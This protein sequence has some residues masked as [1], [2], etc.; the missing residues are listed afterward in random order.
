MINLLDYLFY[1]EKLKICMTIFK[2]YFSYVRMYN[3]WICF[4]LKL[5]IRGDWTKRSFDVVKSVFEW[6][7]TWKASTSTSKSANEWQSSLRYNE[8][9]L[10]IVRVGFYIVWTVKN[11]HVWSSVLGRGQLIVSNGGRLLRVR[12][13]CRFHG[14]EY[15]EPSTSYHD[16]LSLVSWLTLNKC[17]KIYH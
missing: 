12:I 17:P 11:A 5:K 15:L 4:E 13:E 2:V 7:K 6:R 1:D 10:E 9:V 14:C 8:R 16:W 3:F